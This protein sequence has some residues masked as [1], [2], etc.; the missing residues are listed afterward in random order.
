MKKI[1]QLSC[2]TFFFSVCLI[3]RLGG[4]RTSSIGDKQTENIFNVIKN[5]LNKNKSKANNKRLEI[6]LHAFFVYCFCCFIEAK[7]RAQAF[8]L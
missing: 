5:A 6:L 1:L 3:I 8:K 2:K 4:R 7:S